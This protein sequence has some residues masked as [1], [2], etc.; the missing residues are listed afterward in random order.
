[1]S[2]GERFPVTRP[3]VEQIKQQ[4]NESRQRVLDLEE[5]VSGLN[6]NFQTRL[7][8]LEEKVN[9]DRSRNTVQAI[10]PEPVIRMQE[11]GRSADT[12]SSDACSD[13]GRE[14][15]RTSNNSQSDSGSTP[16]GN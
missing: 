16:R 4:L 10:T 11:L 6:D 1:M 8:A 12:A 3:E 7:E 5:Q 14:C 13:G 15:G 2:Q 9:E